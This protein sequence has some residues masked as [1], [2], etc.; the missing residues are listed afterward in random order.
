MGFQN[1]APALARVG[2]QVFV[3]ALALLCYQRER[4]LWS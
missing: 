1:S 3:D 2:A 4:Q